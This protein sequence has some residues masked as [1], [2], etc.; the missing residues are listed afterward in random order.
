MIEMRKRKIREIQAVNRDRNQ[1]SNT[2][3]SIE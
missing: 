3:K 1:D 2:N